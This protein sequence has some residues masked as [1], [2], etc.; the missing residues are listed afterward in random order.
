MRFDLLTSLVNLCLAAISQNIALE[1]REH[2]QH[3]GECSAARR[4]HVQG[5]AQG[6]EAHVQSCQLL[7][8]RHEID[9]RPSPPVCT[10]QLAGFYG[11]SDLDFVVECMLVP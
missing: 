2:G 5:F 10:A 3:T 6:D 7:Q 1:L 8:R 4:R 9:Q 11:Q